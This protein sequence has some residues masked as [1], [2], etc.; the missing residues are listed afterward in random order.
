M[1]DGCRCLPTVRKWPAEFR[2]YAL[3][4]QPCSSK[5]RV[6]TQANQELKPLPVPKLVKEKEV[7]VIAKRKIA[8]PKYRIVFAI[9]DFPPIPGR[10]NPYLSDDRKQAMHTRLTLIS[11]EYARMEQEEI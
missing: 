3:G 6:S 8:V 7:R 2:P 11:D 1:R 10:F 5:C 4:Y 9:R